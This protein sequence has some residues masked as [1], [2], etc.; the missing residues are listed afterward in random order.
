MIKVFIKR[1]TIILGSFGLSACATFGPGGSIFSTPSSPQVYQSTI[2][3]PKTVRL[4]DLLQERRVF[5]EMEIPAGKTLVVQFLKGHG[6]DSIYAPDLM[7]YGVFVNGEASGDL[8]N[9]MSVP[10][11]SS[12]M[13]DVFIRDGFETRES[14]EPR[15]LRTDELLE[16]DYYINN[17]RK[18]DD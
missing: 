15:L 3:S 5:F 10:S 11:S 12:R 8:E 2:H 9:S 14:D 4:I 17:Y 18:V 7:K 1:F 6:D 16:E 13:I